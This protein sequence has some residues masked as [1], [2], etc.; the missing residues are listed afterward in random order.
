MLTHMFARPVPSYKLQHL[1]KKLQQLQNDLDDIL[2]KHGHDVT[3]LKRKNT[4]YK[5][6]LLE[7]RSLSRSEC[8]ARLSQQDAL[9]LIRAAEDLKKIYK[10]HGDRLELREQ[11]RTEL[12]RPHSPLS[13]FS[14]TYKSPKLGFRISP[15]KCGLMVMSILEGA[16][17]SS[18]IREADVIVGV[19]CRR[20]HT[21]STMEECV[22]ILT[23]AQCPKVVHF[24]RDSNNA[25]N[26]G[27][28]PVS[29]QPELSANL[30]SGKRSRP[31]NC[32]F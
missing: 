2:Q 7:T 4:L 23:K 25:E 1:Q 28:R 17:H 16:P 26:S 3:A 32:E 10:L 11:I 27:G 12:L 31:E 9:E 29:R 30:L 18:R 15:V 24:E 19:N 14:L 13:S 21:G 6:L 5:E 22:D 8:R 20:F